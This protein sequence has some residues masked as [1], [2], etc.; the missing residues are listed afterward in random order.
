MDMYARKPSPHTE[1]VLQCMSGLMDFY[2]LLSM[3][4]W[5]FEAASKSSRKFCL[6][7]G[8]VR[9]EAVAQGSELLWKTKP[10]CT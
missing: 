5:D 10:T 2:L 4:G 8:V 1:A 3:D 9:Q 7:Y 6:Q